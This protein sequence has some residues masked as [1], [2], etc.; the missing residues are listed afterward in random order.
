MSHKPAHAFAGIANPNHFKSMLASQGLNVVNFRSFKD[1]FIYS[2]HDIDNI[3]GDSGEMNVITTEKDLV[4]LRDL[5]LP[6]NIYALRIE[7][8]IDDDFFEYIF[9]T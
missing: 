4:K 8:S 5:N 2:Q 7:F 3:I 9:G 6:D 1:H